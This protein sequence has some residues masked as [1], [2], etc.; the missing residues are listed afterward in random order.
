MT[1]RIDGPQG[2]ESAKIKYEIVPYTRGRGLDLG[3]GPF[4]TY[5]HF[6]G[7]D[8]GHHAAEFGWQIK[9]DVH[10]DDCVDL[11]IFGSESMDFVFSSHLLEHIQDYK[12][13][14]AEWWR[15]IKP[16]GHLVLYLPHKRL[17][18]NVGEPGANPD[19]K[20]DFLPEDIIS[21][22]D[23]HDGWDLVEEEDRSDGIEY[24]FFQVYRKTGK[25]GHDYSCY[26]RGDKTV[27][28]CRFGG[29]GDMLQAASL[30]PALKKAGYHVTVMTTPKG[31]DI[32]KADPNVDAWIVQDPDQ[33]P[34]QELHAYWAAQAKRF[35]KFV[36][37]SESIEGTL[38]AMPGRANHAWP[39]S[40]RTR[41]MN[42][43]YLEF[44]FDLAEIPYDPDPHF[45]Q[46]FEE[47]AEVNASELFSVNG[48]F[49]V[50]WA[51]AG[52]SLHKFYPHQ[53]A[54]IAQIMLG[55]PEA[56]VVFVG[57][58][59]CRLLEQGWENEPRVFRMSGELNIRQT[60]TL[61]KKVSCVVGPETGVLNSVA[62]EKDV[63]KVCMLSHST[64]ENLTR[65]WPNTV[66]I[67]APFDPSIPICNNIACH[68]LHYSNEFCPT[69]EMT[70]AA[71]CAI[72]INPDDVYRG[73][74]VAYEAWKTR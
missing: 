64:H 43:N 53:D 26:M 57:D 13:A 38:L 45:Y 16:G 52:S 65:D 69:D 60:L 23:A 71:A 62:F 41:E 33:V 22:M 70:G 42:K 2:N 63:A 31:K 21:A 56:V 68:R 73:I 18:P 24:S 48:R 32:I 36:Q 28:I 17:Y 72:S 46:T 39:N 40:I 4:K 74:E 61:A 67:S 7:V 20:H 27:C 55:M 58:E 14:L 5:P 8:N 47:E 44:T 3:C 49:T 19:H 11:S 66:S 59:A 50:M 6:I 30:F 25:S 37:L 9:P 35:T 10:V 29:F 54:V 51:L 1:W 15:V 12:A 34:N